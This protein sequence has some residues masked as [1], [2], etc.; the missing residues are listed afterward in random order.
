M[1]INNHTVSKRGIYVWPPVFEKLFGVFLL[2]TFPIPVSFALQ[3]FTMSS[4]YVIYP[5]YGIISITYIVAI[6]Y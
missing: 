6:F 1:K 4:V 2:L 5:F 3:Y